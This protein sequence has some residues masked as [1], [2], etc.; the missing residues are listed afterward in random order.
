MRV[1]A[2]GG[3]PV[4]VTPQAPDDKQHVMP[5]F[6]PDGSRFLYAEVSTIDARNSRHDVGRGIG[7]RV[8][9]DVVDR[10]F[11]EQHIRAGVLVDDL[12]PQPAD[13]GALG[14]VYAS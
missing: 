2:G 1:S 9:P 5:S 12:Y 14:A 4:A 6:L 10:S 11:G 13:A 8:F 3:T 7:E